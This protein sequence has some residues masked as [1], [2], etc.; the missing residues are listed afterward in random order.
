MHGEQECPQGREGKYQAN[1]F[2]SAFLMPRDSILAAGLFG[3]TADDIIRAKG[4]WHVSAM[5]LAR[6]LNSLKLSVRIGCR[7]RRWFW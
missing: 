1:D 3:A 2:A 6:R 4:K 5:A 7:S